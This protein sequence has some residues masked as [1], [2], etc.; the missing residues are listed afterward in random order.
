M[1]RKKRFW[2]WTAFISFLLLLWGVVSCHRQ[3]QNFTFVFLTDIHIQPEKNAPQGFEKAITL[4][5]KLDPD[6]VIT[7]GDLISDA[8]GQNFEQAMSFYDL[9]LRLSK[10][11]NMPVWNTIGNHE[12]FGLLES[13]GVDPSHP[14]YF[15][16]MYENRIGKRYYSFDYQDW[17]FMALDSI[18]ATDD[19]KY[20]GWVGTDQLEW[21]AEDL[22]NIE[23]ETPIVI[24]THIPFI[25]VD[26]QIRKG[27][28]EANPRGLVVVNSK[29]VLDL[30]K[31]HNLKLVLQGHLHILEAITA[32]GITFITGGAIS[33]EWWDGPYHGVEEGFVLVKVKGQTFDWEYIDY[34][35]EAVPEQEKLEDRGSS[36]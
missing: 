6:F 12:I 34:G 21:I 15:K 24:S 3:N 32:A 25:T 9:Y 27:S 31:N 19:R 11:F 10:G 28:T 23:P 7:G 2:R 4:I 20:I 18:D 22:Q 36:L 17:H 29:Q 35:W 8:L 33:G 30:F 16:K 13:S 26:R 14:Q 1:N 5:N